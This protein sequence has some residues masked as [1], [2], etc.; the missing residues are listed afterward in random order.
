MKQL[1]LIGGHPGK[2]GE[3]NALAYALRTHPASEVKI[4]LCNFARTDTEW[5]D[6]G[7]D[8]VDMFNRFGTGKKLAFRKMESENLRKDS[9][10]ADVIYMPGGHPDA[11][12]AELVKYPDIAKLWDG[13][14]I[15]GSSAG[16]DVMCAQFVFLQR[17]TFGEGFGW[18]QATL[19]PHWGHYKESKYESYSD[20]DFEFVRDKA[21]KHRPDLPVLCIPEGQ[22]VEFA[23]Q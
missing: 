23:V 15:A 16:A 17:K 22:F 11:L 9:K 2:A 4:A 19:I 18:V 5:D 12:Q 14:I 6:T 8:S 20:E 10:W 3:D 7:K 21:L 1:I 13:K